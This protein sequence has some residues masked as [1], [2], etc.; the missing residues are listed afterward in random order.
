MAPSALQRA[1]DHTAASFM[2]S[3]ASLVP[4]EAIAAGKERKTPLG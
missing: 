3:S 1:E 2:F 4:S